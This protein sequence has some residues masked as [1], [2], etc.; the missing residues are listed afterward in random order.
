MLKIIMKIVCLATAWPLW[1]VSANKDRF[2]QWRT[3]E[4]GLDG[5]KSFRPFFDCAPSSGFKVFSAVHDRLPLICPDQRRPL[6]A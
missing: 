1:Q 5:E 2:S 6:A 4:M 3:S